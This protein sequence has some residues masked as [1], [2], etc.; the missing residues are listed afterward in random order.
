[1]LS[2]AAP[3]EGWS[4]WIAGCHPRTRHVGPGT[5]IGIA[6]TTMLRTVPGSLVPVGSTPTLGHLKRKRIPW[7]NG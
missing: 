2:R 7:S 4:A 1:M 6:A 5:Q 3:T